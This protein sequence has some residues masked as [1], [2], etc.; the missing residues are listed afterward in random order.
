MRKETEKELITLGKD[1]LGLPRAEI[2]GL[3]IAHNCKEPKRSTRIR[4]RECQK[5][6]IKEK[7]KSRPKCMLP[8]PWINKKHT[9]LAQNF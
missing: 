6:K 7:K 9:L 1:M 3:N 4:V 8:G 2:S 5:K